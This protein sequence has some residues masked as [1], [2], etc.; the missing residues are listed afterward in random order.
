MLNSFIDTFV[1]GLIG[2]FQARKYCENERTWAKIGQDAISSLRKWA[3]GSEY[4]F[5]NKLYLLEAEGAFYAKEDDACVM[6]YYNGAISAARDHHFVHEHGLAEEK[7]ATF[8][9]HRKKY[10]DAMTHF[11]NAKK[12][13]EA[14]GADRL[15]KRIGD[16]I[17]ILLPQCKEEEEKQ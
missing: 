9:L 13:Y 3:L 10:N 12:C 11:K 6:K 2:F 16:A 5:I 8:L 1:D 15:V 4:N 14:W 7:A 17:E